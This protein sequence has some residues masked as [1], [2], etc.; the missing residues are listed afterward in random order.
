MTS[1]KGFLDRRADGSLRITRDQ[2]TM[3]RRA[4]SEVYHRAQLAGAVPEDL[5]KL[6]V[7]VTGDCLSAVP[8]DRSC[9]T[10]DYERDGHCLQWRANIPPDAVDAGC[11]HHQTDSA[12]F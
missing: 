12:P 8:A 4:M 9:A 3:L 7:R 11:E 10:C 1:T 6:V 5:L 2:A